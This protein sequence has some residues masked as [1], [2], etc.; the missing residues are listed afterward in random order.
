V[1]GGRRGVY[2]KGK[3]KREKETDRERER[4]VGS[5]ATGGLVVGR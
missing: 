5:E 2:K 4:A 3:E 1:W